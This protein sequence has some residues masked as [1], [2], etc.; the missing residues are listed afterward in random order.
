MLLFMKKVCVCVCVSYHIRTSHLLTHLQ[1][2]HVSLLKTNTA[3]DQQERPHQ[4]A[5]LQQRKI[6]KLDELS[7]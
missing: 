1:G 7:V 3:V 4:T 5:G 6:I 2:D